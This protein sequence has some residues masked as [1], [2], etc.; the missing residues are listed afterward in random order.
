M[1][2]VGGDVSNDMSGGNTFKQGEKVRKKN[3]KKRKIK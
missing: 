2:R 3:D 1:I